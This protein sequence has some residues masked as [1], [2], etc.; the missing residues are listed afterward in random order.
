MKFSDGKAGIDLVQLFSLDSLDWPE[1]QELGFD[2]LKPMKN[3][4]V[5]QSDDLIILQNYADHWV[6]YG[7]QSL[8]H[9][10]FLKARG[11]R[12]WML[13]S[14]LA[15]LTHDRLVGF[16]GVSE[17][18]WTTARALEASGMWLESFA[19]IYA[20]GAPPQTIAAVCSKPF[21]RLWALKDL[22][23]FGRV[24]AKQEIE[25]TPGPVRA[26]VTASLKQYRLDELWAFVG[27]GLQEKS[28]GEPPARILVRPDQPCPGEGPRMPLP[29]SV[30][31]VQFLPN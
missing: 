30:R 1:R 14:Y 5:Y 6:T 12:G 8:Q 24:L 20:G 2:R 11:V 19:G 29:P 27:M 7:R 18:I 26:A 17:Q 25:E 16:A 10:A 9:A 4:R 23:H 28:P 13:E 31:R 3:V 21:A 15:A 22:H